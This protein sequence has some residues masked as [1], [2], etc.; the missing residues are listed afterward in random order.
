MLALM[1]MGSFTT[2]ARLLVTETVQQLSTRNKAKSFAN[3]SLM[4]LCLALLAQLPA[5]W[6]RLKKN[7]VSSDHCGLLGGL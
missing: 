6:W 4:G 2:S 3:F 5:S 1:G 7:P